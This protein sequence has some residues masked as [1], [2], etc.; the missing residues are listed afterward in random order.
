MKAKITNIFRRPLL[1]VIIFLFLYFCIFFLYSLQRLNMLW[2]SYFDLGIMHQTVWNTYKAIQA[3]DLS[4]FLL[5]TDPHGSGEQIYRMAIHADYALALIAPLYFIWNGPETLLFVQTAALASGA[6]AIYNITNKIEKYKSKKVKILSIVFPVVYLMNFAVQRTNY[7]EFH[8][9]TLATPLILWMYAAY[10]YKRYLAAFLLGALAILTKEQVGFSIAAFLF[11]EAVGSMKITASSS[12]VNI[13][14]RI[15]NTEA[16][17][18]KFFVY[19]LLSLFSFS[20]VVL[21]VFYVMPAFRRGDDHFAL[22]YFTS[23]NPGNIFDSISSYSLRLFRFESVRYVGHLFGSLAF[24]PIFS[25]YAL[26]AIPDLLINILSESSNMRNFY[27][28]YTAVITPW[29]FISLIHSSKRILFRWGS[30]AFFYFY[31][32]LLLSLCVF[33][34]YLESPLPYSLRGG[35][36]RLSKEAKELQDIRTW[37]NMLADDEIPVASTGQLAPYLSGRRYFY[38]FDAN[39]TKAHYV[40]LRRNEVYNYPDRHKL[41]PVYEDLVKDIGYRLVYAN[42]Q[43]EVFERIQGL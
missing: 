24:L 29:L 12:I 13:W 32:L 5:L 20:Y 40:L 38:D 37:Q 33:F 31:I 30:K 2:A 3:L 34:S 4:R 41:I 23:D 14:L 35:P 11:I 6:V 39:Y 9:V 10:I 17:R 28:H 22:S 43:F 15:R 7:Y 1:V 19:F 25:I 18:K 26:P 21:T 8:A 36:L 42:G 16:Y 27:Y